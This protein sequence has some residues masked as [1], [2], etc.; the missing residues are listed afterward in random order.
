MCVNSWP[1]HASLL[2]LPGTEFVKNITLSRKRSQCSAGL[3]KHFPF[4]YSMNY[5]CSIIWQKGKWYIQFIDI[6]H[7][8]HLKVTESQNHRTIMV[9]KHLWRLSGPIKSWQPAAI[10][11]RGILLKWV[12]ASWWIAKE[13]LDFEILPWLSLKLRQKHSFL[14]LEIIFS[15]KIAFKKI[16]Y[17]LS[18][19]GGIFL[20]GSEMLIKFVKCLLK[21]IS[22]F[23]QR[24][25]TW[26]YY[27]GLSNYVLQK[28]K[29]IK[30]PSDWKKAMSKKI[31]VKKSS[32]LIFSNLMHKQLLII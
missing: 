16:K 17:I 25:E 29:N 22:E 23:D 21:P 5:S 26:I 2:S 11:N 18:A 3:G 14:P 7:Y 13:L 10:Y 6:S 24:H 8:L 30:S 31:F 1:L 27:K 4:W 19:S 28:K 9:G 20:E 32:Y 15:I 12:S